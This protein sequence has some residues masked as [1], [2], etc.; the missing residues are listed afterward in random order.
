M[1]KL[2]SIFSLIATLLCFHGAFPDLV[3]CFQANGRIELETSQNGSCAH[4]HASEP[5]KA[6]CSSS[7]SLEGDD[8]GPCQDVPFLIN[9]VIQYNLVSKFKNFFTAD[10]WHISDLFPRKISRVFSRSFVSSSFL[11]HSVQSITHI[12]PLRI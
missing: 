10:V 2:I 1:S 3:L 9:D 12:A 8:C 4:F 11:I 6:Q 5:G 7:H